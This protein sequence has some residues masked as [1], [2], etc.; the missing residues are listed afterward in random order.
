MPC[1]EGT[2][3]YASNTLPL[4]GRRGSRSALTLDWLLPGLYVPA[5]V[6]GS[7]GKGAEGASERWPFSP[8]APAAGKIGCLARRLGMKQCPNG[9]WRGWRR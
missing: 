7:M 6:W 9:H 8:A 4:G 2:A 1:Y 5:Q 3:T